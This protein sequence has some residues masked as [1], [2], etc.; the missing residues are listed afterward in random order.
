MKEIELKEKI[1][2]LERGFRLL[3]DDLE[4]AMKLKKEIEEI[5]AEIKALKIYLGRVNPDFKS[6]YPEV[7]KKLKG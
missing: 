3:G 2:H 4:N 6:Q 7:V 1:S 5:K